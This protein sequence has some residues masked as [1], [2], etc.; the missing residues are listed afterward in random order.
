MQSAKYTHLAFNNGGQHL[1]YKDVLTR[2]VN[3]HP[4]G[5]ILQ[6]GRRSFHIGRLSALLS[7]KMVRN[8]NKS[9]S[10]QNEKYPM[11]KGRP[12]SFYTYSYTSA[13][14]LYC[15]VCDWVFKTKFGM[16]THIGTRTNTLGNN[17]W[18]SSLLKSIRL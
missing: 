17:F 16:V 10:N 14:K 9:D 4:I 8:S 5:S 18:G 3:V 12:K 6:D 7:A 11:R 13:P 15:S 1:W 2:H